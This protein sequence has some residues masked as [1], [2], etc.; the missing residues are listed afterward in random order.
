MQIIT[1][2]IQR[3]YFKIYRLFFL[4]LKIR[5][6]GDP[7][8]IK[9]GKKINWERGVLLSTCGGGR[10]EIGDNCE[11]KAGSKLATY[12]G[13]IILGK[14][15]SVNYNTILYGHGGLKIGNYVRIAAGCV[16]VPA[17]HQFGP[18]RLIFEQDLIRKGIL[19]EDNVWI[20]AG[21][22]ILDGVTI[23][24]GSV[25]G[26]GTVVTKSIG[27]YELHAGVPNRL[28]KRLKDE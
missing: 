16:L 4:P 26:A 3:L 23:G 24:R 15:T 28:L 5:V 19:I 21:A 7:R 20:G 2:A 22:I 6:E 18:D 8:R 9:L 27:N 13:E 1:K 17:N 14:Y 10:I 12:G 11:I 25:I